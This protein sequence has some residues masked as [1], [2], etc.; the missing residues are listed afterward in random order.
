MADGTVAAEVR[1]A[2]HR[3]PILRLR[4]GDRLA[5]HGPLLGRTGERHGTACALAGD[6]FRAAVSLECL[7]CEEVSHEESLSPEGAYFKAAVSLT[8][9][10]ERADSQRD[11]RRADPENGSRGHPRAGTGQ[12]RLRD[13]LAAYV[14]VFRNA[15]DVGFRAC[16]SRGCVTDPVA[17]DDVAG[18]GSLA[19]KTRGRRDHAQR[20][21]P[22]G[23]AAG[24]FC[25]VRHGVD[26]HGYSVPPAAFPINRFLF[27]FLSTSAMA[28]M[29]LMN[30]GCPQVSAL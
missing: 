19:A 20:A 26:A 15:A 10:E 23:T 7:A 21:S 5:F 25:E 6:G 9:Q 3:R 16:Y 28:A 29:D 2:G 11:D 30:A 1:L 18:R 27:L 13:K 12:R 8:E 22:K 24:T 14:L 17:A 4:D